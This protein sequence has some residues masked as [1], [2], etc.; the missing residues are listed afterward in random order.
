MLL[1]IIFVF[2]IF[3]LCM[4]NLLNTHKDS[5][6]IQNLI[7]QY[8]IGFFSSISFFFLLY[9]L[10]V[11]IK[12]R[13]VYIV[14]LYCGIMLTLSL[15][16]ICRGFLLKKFKIKKIKIKLSIHEIFFLIIIICLVS[17]QLY[18]A[19]FYKEAGGLSD[20]KYD[21]L[22]SVKAIHNNFL[23]IATENEG[24][25]TKL[26]SNMIFWPTYFAFLSEILG[27]SVLFVVETIFPIMFILL[28][29]TIYYLLS[30]K[31][32]EKLDKRLMFLCLIAVLN[33][34]GFYS[35]FSATTFFMGNLWKG[36]SIIFFIVTPL[37]IT[38][39]P[40]IFEDDINIQNECIIVVMSIVSCFTSLFGVVMWGMLVVLTVVVLSVSRKKVIGIKQMAISCVVTII[41]LSC[42][43]G[44]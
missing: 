15:A 5:N 30:I 36:K 12:I 19:V 2:L 26:G 23:N 22:M 21:F 31:L 14:Y 16:V 4:G 43:L 1:V 25:L 18:F 41:Q 42:V 44:R 33:I 17:L 39:L 32:F 28:I 6:G 9:M 24:F 10:M 13:F 8:I 20:E 40:E 27:E 3:P 7:W 37:L 35:D 29:Y 34:F 38:L 11:F